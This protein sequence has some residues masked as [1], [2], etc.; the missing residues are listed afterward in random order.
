MV[1]LRRGS[2]VRDGL[3]A[4]VAQAPPDRHGQGVRVRPAEL[5]QV[6]IAFAL[7]IDH[8]DLLLGVPKGHGGLGAGTAPA[9]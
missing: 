6:W 8:H 5:E 3:G 9:L 2:E 7:Q 1:V 4:T